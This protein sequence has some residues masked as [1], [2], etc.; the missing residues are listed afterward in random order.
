MDN[1]LTETEQPQPDDAEE[2]SNS[3]KGMHAGGHSRTAILIL[4][5]MFRK[6]LILNVALALDG[7]SQRL[8][9]RCEKPDD[10][11]RSDGYL[12]AIQAES[13]GEN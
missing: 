1:E 13:W 11:S 2:V 9:E 4:L 8:D 7:Q 10:D 5:L 12:R 6:G 3:S